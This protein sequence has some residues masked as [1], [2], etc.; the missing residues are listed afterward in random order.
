MGD[1][2]KDKG[3][4]QDALARQHELIAQEV[5]KHKDEDVDLENVSGGW[6]IS[7]TTDPSIQ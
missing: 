4:V 1:T 3:K 7:Y 2:Q 6:S 5:E